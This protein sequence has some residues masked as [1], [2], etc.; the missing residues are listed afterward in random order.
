[1]ESIEASGKSVE[2]AITQAL[3]RLGKRRD[4][5]DIAVLQEPSRGAFGLGSRDARVRVTARAAVPSV[6]VPS[7]V[8]TPEMADAM[9]GPGGIEVPLPDDDEELYER[10][11][12]MRNM[13]MRNMKMRKKN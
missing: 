7:A 1:M 6:N 8:I 13:R 2:E 4:E 12:T 11:R 10:R 3:V 9:L 5:V